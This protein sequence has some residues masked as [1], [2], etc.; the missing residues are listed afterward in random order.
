MLELLYRKQ[1][2]PLP[3]IHVVRRIVQP[4]SNQHCIAILAPVKDIVHDCT[5]VVYNS[6]QITVLKLNTLL[7]VVVMMIRTQSSQHTITR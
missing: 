2:A 5:A 6:T 1:S 4:H 3:L 7:V